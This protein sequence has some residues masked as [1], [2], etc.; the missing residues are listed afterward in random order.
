MSNN[1][2]GI[3][4][5]EFKQLKAGAGLLSITINVTP[6]PT[7][8]KK[9]LRNKMRYNFS[10]NC[11]TFLKLKNKNNFCEHDYNYIDFAEISTSF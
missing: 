7:K 11:K 8:N 3:T 2:I 4:L 10:T 9:N 1:M 6:G 5:L